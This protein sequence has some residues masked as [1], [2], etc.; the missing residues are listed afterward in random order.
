MAGTTLP[1]TF[2]AAPL[3]NPFTATP[4]EFLDA[5]V[6]RLTIESQDELSFFVTGSVAPTSDVG[7][8]IK[9][10][11]TWYVWSSAVGA[12]VPETIEFESLR[13][14]A[15]PTSTPPDQ[16]KYVFWI[17]LDNTGK[18]ISLNYYSG[19]AWKSVYEDKF[20]TYSTTTQMN[21][22]INIAITATRNKY[23]VIANIAGDGNINVDTNPHRVLFNNKVFDDYTLF[24]VINNNYTC[25]VAGLYQVSAEV[26]IEDVSAVPA[27]I[28]FS[29]YLGKNGSGGVG[30]CAVGM[31]IPSPSGSRWY[32]IFSGMCLAAAGDT[33]AC[34][35]TANDGVNTGAVKLS[36][37]YFTINLVQQTG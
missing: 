18:A 19:G 20:L 35:V 11:I 9:N 13:Y 37:G 31:Q 6:A 16:N 25:P 28:E 33:L 23:P 3:T 7:P 30:S 4:Q 12:Y 8:W 26:Q 15:A 1:V 32:P 27:D 10:G 24:S 2:R 22:A 21:S 34:Y 29:F 17:E 36:N 14:I 5:I